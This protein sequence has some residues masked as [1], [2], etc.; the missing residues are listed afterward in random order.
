MALSDYDRLDA[1]GL[2]SRIAR[3]EVT[4]AD[5]RNPRLNAL[6]TR[7]DEAARA[8]A[9]GP[10]PAGPLSGV[11]FLWKDLHAAWAGHGLTGSSRLRAGNVASVN[12]LVVERG[13]AAGLVAFGQTNLPEFGIM[14]VT[15]PALRGPCRN[16]WNTDHTPGGSSG[17]AGAAVAARIVPAAH[18]TDHGGSVRIPASACGILGLKTS[19]GRVPFAPDASGVWDGWDSHGILCRSVRDAAAFLDAF[20]RGPSP[21][22]P[23]PLPAPALSY[24]EAAMAPPGRLRIA[25]SPGPFFGR[26]VHPECKAAVEDAAR[27]LAGLGHEVVE[28]RPTFDRDALV[29]AYLVVLAAGVAADVAESEAALGRKARWEELEPETWALAVGG[30]VLTARE[31]AAAVRDVHRA[32][33][34]LALFHE[35]HDL[36]LT[37]TLAHPPVRLGALAAKPHERAALRLFAGVPTRA[38]F[39]VLFHQ[40][41]ERSFD[42][43]GNTMLFNETGQPAA[44]VPL[45]WTA[46]GLPVGVQLVGRYGDEATLLQVAA[47]LETAR[48]WADRVPPGLEPPRG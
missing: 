25:W 4:P 36:L 44:S 9:R 32:S 8:R 38:M 42:A 21:G 24:S 2:A 30:R 19:R 40:L 43:T 23:Y 1:V 31:V 37:P 28:E 16:P 3:R 48:P 35:R 10:L 7:D 41:S 5:A 11:P 29:R 39:E 34:A 20:A 27:L 22:D 6:V 18:G 33:R 45:H 47:Q 46:D 13:L 14:G 12:A 17:G 15:E 26:T